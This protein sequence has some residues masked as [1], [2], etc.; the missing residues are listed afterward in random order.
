MLPNYADIVG[1]V[2]ARPIW[3]LRG[4]PRYVP[5]RPE[6][7]GGSEVALIH[8]EC[9]KCRMRYDV[10][11]VPQGPSYS[12]L[13]TL[14]A[15]ENAVDVG[16]PPFAC[17]VLG[18]Q[19]PAGY[20]MTSLEMAVLEFWHWERH[21]KAVPT[22]RRDSSMERPLA[23]ANLD[24]GG[25][26]DNGT[27]GRIRASARHSEWQDARKRGDFEAMVA[28]LEAFGCERAVEVANMQDIDRRY[29]LLREEVWSRTEQRKGR[30]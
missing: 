1:R 21:E 13:R 29:A 18:A 5:F 23:D 12:S 27:W 2:P 3:W 4:V 11:A 20:S 8:T 9:Q 26:P 6:M 10:A 7:V 25:P 15:F 28:I 22:W 19:C 17:H 24:S 14:I 16:D 30:V